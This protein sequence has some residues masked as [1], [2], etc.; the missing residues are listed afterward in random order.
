MNQLAVPIV[1]LAAWLALT[2]LAVRRHGP[3]ILWI[4]WIPGG[5][6]VAYIGAWL[7]MAGACSS[8][9]GCV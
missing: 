7:L 2:L 8:G 6:I 9:H 3:R 4:V 5:V 1:A